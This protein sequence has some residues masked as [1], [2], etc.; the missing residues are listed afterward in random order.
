MTLSRQLI[1]LI[2]GLVMLLFIGTLAISVQNTRAYLESQ[3]ESHAQDAATSLGLSATT[4]VASG[5][6]AIVTAMVNAMFHRGRY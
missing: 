6:Q 2:T 5:D 1:L 4:H 3:L